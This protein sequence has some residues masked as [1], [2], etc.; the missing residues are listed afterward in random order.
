MSA[1]TSTGRFFSDVAGDFALVPAGTGFLP[2][3]RGGASGAVGLGD[4]AEADT[5]G[6]AVTGTGALGV[7][8]TGALDFAGGPA[9]G[10]F[11]ASAVGAC[12]ASRVR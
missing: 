4:G 1:P 5:I 6:V 8:A 9:G 11:A 10:A 12:A 7:T 3:G 2:A